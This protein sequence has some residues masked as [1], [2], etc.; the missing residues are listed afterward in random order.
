MLNPEQLSKFEAVCQTI[1]SWDRSGID[2][3]KERAQGLMWKFF[4]SGPFPVLPP[5]FSPP[6]TSNEES[7]RVNYSW[8][9]TGWDVMAGPQD[10]AEQ[11]DGSW[12]SA[13]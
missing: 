9:R 1:A 6:I 2:S 13:Y 7:V 12:C 11:H 3:D 4:R 8:Q 5:S 10:E